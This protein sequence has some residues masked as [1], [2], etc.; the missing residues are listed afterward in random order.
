[1]EVSSCLI[2]FT[3]AVVVA[4]HASSH[5]VPS[6]VLE[7]TNTYRHIDDKQKSRLVYFRL[8]TPLSLLPRYR[9]LH[10][11]GTLMVCGQHFEKLLVLLAPLYGEGIAV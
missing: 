11:A 4:V 1:M 7:S 6:C 5:A 2:S 9:C 10:T 8:Q 3:D